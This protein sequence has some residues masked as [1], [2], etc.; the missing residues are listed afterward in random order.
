MLTRP[1]LMMDIKGGQCILLER[2]AGVQR[3]R[4]VMRGLKGLIYEERLKR[5]NLARW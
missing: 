1:W 2:L 3:A 5:C 4:E